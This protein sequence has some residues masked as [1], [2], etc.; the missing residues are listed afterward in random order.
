[1]RLSI[2][3]VTKLVKSGKRVLYYTDS[4]HSTSTLL[5]HMGTLGVM[6]FSTRQ[7]PETNGRV[8]ETFNK[9]EGKILLTDI[10]SGYKI[11]GQV[12][13][14]YMQELPSEHAHQ[15][16][17]RVYRLNNPESPNFMVYD[18][19]GFFYVHVDALIKT[20]KPRLKPKP[21]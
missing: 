14:G 8:L 12:Y 18:D 6:I 13:V 5:F 1:M 10:I 16:F 19:S 17:H 9:G 2:D 11:D 7:T 20:V 3:G 4:P 21:R 15:L